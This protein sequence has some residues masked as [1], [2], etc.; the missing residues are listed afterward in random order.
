[1]AVRK[2]VK[3]KAKR[4]QAPAGKPARRKKSPRTAKKT[5]PVKKKVIKKKVAAA[6]RTP[7]RRKPATR[8]EPEPRAPV[9]PAP[10]P[11]TQPAA[12]P[13][14]K[15]VVP[16]V[17]VA[18]R[19][20]AEGEERVGVVTHYYSHLSVAV[21]RLESGSLRVGDTIRINGHTTDFRQR[22]DSLQIEHETVN[23]VGP[24]DDFGIKVIEHARE[25]DV[26]YKLPRT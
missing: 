6:R 7:P 21:I 25:H 11:K 18:A 2:K 10:K 23:E 1:M 13:P 20:P 3:A 19:L 5:A 16:A 15:P 4:K 24:G 9:R 22:V 12:I 17:P 26:V 8:P 14:A